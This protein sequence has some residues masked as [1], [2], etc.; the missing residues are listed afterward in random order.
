MDE[1]QTRGKDET[2]NQPKMRD[3]GVLELGESD[4]ESTIL[5]RGIIRE[6]QDLD[7]LEKLPEL[8][9]IKGLKEVEIK[10]LG[11]LE[12][13]LRRWNDQLRPSGR[14][15]WVNIVS[16]PIATWKETVFRRL[17]ALWG[18]VMETDNCS[19]SVVIVETM[20][21]MK[22]IYME[23]ESSEEEDE[24]RDYSPKNV[25]VRKRREREESWGER[26]NLKFKL[27]GHNFEGNN[28]DSEVHVVAETCTFREVCDKVREKTEGYG[29]NTL[30]IRGVKTKDGGADLEDII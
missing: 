23:V 19:L 7:Y 1:S 26:R 20:T 4:I 16:V 3:I 13:L 30:E 24:E 6:V 22:K 8:C 5:N 12:R 28:V 18:S 25:C 29:D 2:F 21:M 14:L 11:R 9:E 15:T 17:M 27:N 10:Y